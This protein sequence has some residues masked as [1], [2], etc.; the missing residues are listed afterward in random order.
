MFGHEGC[1]RTAEELEAEVAELEGHRNSGMNLTPITS[2]SLPRVLLE[3]LHH[4]NEVADAIVPSGRVGCLVYEE[5]RPPSVVHRHSIKG[6]HCSFKVFQGLSKLVWNGGGLH[7][8]H[9][10]LGNPIVL[11]RLHLSNGQY[12]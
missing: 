8:Y 4:F 12:L 2:A 6:S 3:E 10:L 11:P 7:V 5:E 1:R 9:L